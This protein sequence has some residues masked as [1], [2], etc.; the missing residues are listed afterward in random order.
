MSEEQVFC[1]GEHVHYLSRQSNEWIPAVVQGHVMVGSSRYYNLDVQEAAEPSRVMSKEQYQT[2]QAKNTAKSP[3]T[4][5]N[6]EVFCFGEQVLYLSRSTGQWIPA[7]V[8]GHLMVDQELH[9]QLDVQDSA[10]P[11]R[12]KRQP[13]QN[14][15]GT[16]DPSEMAPT[17]PALPDLPVPLV[18]SVPHVPPENLEDSVC[19]RL[20]SVPRAKAIS[21]PRGIDSKMKIEEQP[22]ITAAELEDV[23]ERVERPSNL[24]SKKSFLDE[25][26][27]G[28]ATASFP[29]VSFMSIPV[30]SENGRRVNAERVERVSDLFSRKTFLDELNEPH[31]GLSTCDSL[32]DGIQQKKSFLLATNAR[33]PGHMVECRA[34]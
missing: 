17:V 27:F 21:V 6:S 34:H 2:Y 28:L 22:E 10:H 13:K 9:Y 14:G 3:V 1:F 8:Q 11:C 19:V 15:A 33:V 16:V 31:F 32:E 7:V 18:D 26:H 25:P 30:A 23:C 5:P 20:A 24:F 12:V 29:D 4:G